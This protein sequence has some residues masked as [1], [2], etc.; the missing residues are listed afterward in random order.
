[1]TTYLYA[2]V[3]TG[4]QN[5]EQQLH[6]LAERYSFD[7]AFSETFTGTTTSRPV[8]D[9]LITRLVQGDTL[10]VK[11]VSRLGRNTGEVSLLANGLRERGVR[12]I[13]DQ[14]G[15]VDVTSSAGKMIF[16]VMAAMAEMERE[17]MRERQR[18]GIKRAQKE[19]KYAA[20]GRKGVSDDLLQMV[21]V[22]HR[23][24]IK[25]ETISKQTGLGLSTVYRLIKK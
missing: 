3:S 2:R 1:M 21:K 5:V 15:G 9:E 20:V 18:I 13:V 11:E 4:G 12:L 7:E 8:F 22:Q 24:G 19:G 25:A 10:V 17:Q 16:D 6:Y 14:L 23:H